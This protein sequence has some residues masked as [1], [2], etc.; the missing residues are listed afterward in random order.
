MKPYCITGKRV[1][2][3]NIPNEFNISKYRDLRTYEGIWKQ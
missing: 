2:K 1:R 3:V